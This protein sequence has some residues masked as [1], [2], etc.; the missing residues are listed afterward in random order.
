ME[1]SS[2]WRGMADLPGV[3]AGV[4]VVLTLMPSLGRGGAKEVAQPGGDLAVGGVEKGWWLREPYNE[5]SG[6]VVWPKP[7]SMRM[8]RSSHRAGRPVRILEGLAYWVWSTTTPL[9]MECRHS[10]A[11]G[12]AMSG[13]ARVP[14]FAI[15]RAGPSRS[16][17]TGCT[18]RVPVG[19]WSGGCRGAVYWEG[20][21]TALAATGRQR[22]LGVLGL[23]LTF[24]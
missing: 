17:E 9:S 5:E 23:V 2:W 14:G 21:A 4:A 16:L 12:R 1:Y 6:G 19:S 15:D 8:G 3:V 24:A 7:C 11:F 13:P 20:G 10:A 18:P 22:S